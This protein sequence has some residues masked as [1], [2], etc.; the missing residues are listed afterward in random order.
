[1]DQVIKLK[2]IKKLLLS[3]SEDDVILGIEFLNERYQGSK[4]KIERLMDRLSGKFQGNICL[5]I[6]TNK[7]NILIELGHFYMYDPDMPPV[8]NYRIVKL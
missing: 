7:C 4:Y 8:K 2:T 5:D 1:M 6:Y 3:G